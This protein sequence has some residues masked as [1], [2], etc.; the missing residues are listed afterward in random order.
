MPKDE[1]PWQSN[2]FIGS[3]PSHWRT[4]V[5]NYAQVEYHNVYPGIDLI[6][7]G[8][9]GQLEYD[10]VIAPGSDAHS[11]ILNFPDTAT[12]RLDAHGNLQLDSGSEELK[13]HK[14]AAYQVIDGDKRP[15]AAAYSLSGGAVGFAIGDYDRTKPLVIDP[16]LSYSTYLGGSGEDRGQGIAVDASGAVYVVGQSASTDFA[17]QNPFQS[18]SNGG[19]DVFVAK[20]NASGTGLVYSTFL[21][22]TNDD[23]G[24]GIAVDGAGNAYIT[25]QTDSPD[26]PLSNALQGAN[27]G[28]EDAFVSKLSPTGSALLYSTYLGGNGSDFASSIAIDSS[29][30]AY[31][32]GTT[33]SPDFPVMNPIQASDAGGSDAF[34]TKLNPAGSALVYSTYLGGA[35]I[36]SATAIAVDAV[37][38]AYITGNTDS[39]TFPTTPGAFDTSCGCSTDRFYYYIFRDAWLAK[40]D[41]TGS[42]LD[43]S[44][45]LGGAGDDLATG[46]AVDASGQA[47]VTGRTDSDD[48]PLQNPVQGLLGGSGDSFVTALNATGSALVFSTYLGG[49]SFDEGAGIALDNSG[50][51]Y[52]SGR[53]LSNDFPTKSTFQAT[54]G[55]ASDAY[56]AKLSSSGSLTYSS[57]L[58][59][60]VDED[61]TSGGVA[62]DGSGNVY[63]T[64]DTSSSNYPTRSPLQANLRG[65][66]DAFVTKISAAAATGAD[67]SLSTSVTPSAGALGGNLTYTLTV[68][69]H[70]PD[71]ATGVTLTDALG[72]DV[73]FTSAVASQGSCS[74]TGPV[75]CALGSLANGKGANVSLIVST[76]KGAIVNNVASVTA[77]ESD[78]SSGNNMATLQTVVNA[79]FTVAVAPATATVKAGSSA[80]FTLTIAAGGGPFS[81]DISLACSGLPQLSQCN[82][83][84]SVVNLGT[85]ASASTNATVSVMTTASIGTLKPLHEIHSLYALWFSIFSLVLIWTSAGRKKKRVSLIWLAG[86]FLLPLLALQVAC[87]GGGQ[88]QITRPG[89]PTGSFTITITASSAG[90]AHSV[91]ANL[92]VQ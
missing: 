84:P 19:F 41:A 42:A 57:Y 34:V 64:G 20:L 82:F 53:T 23:F 22:G 81:N 59:G 31:V 5:S 43:Y 83:S 80:V 75:T 90:T 14:P 71:N 11:I 79:D 24:A 88:N 49:S 68:S 63:V 91:T 85:D 89:T 69:N 38:S 9:Q 15:V 77:N 8:D 73:T 25:G 3:N 60:V 37:G 70:G 18:T 33:G 35:D 66:F 13:L 45:F 72:P 76:P 4:A 40:I 32:A 87:G 17:T 36:D 78:S 74:G 21:G 51:A 12:L 54:L 92:T 67:L 44:T 6:Y 28:G 50:N 46:I 10:F 61:A 48:F 29:G 26:F 52:V 30:N 62:V 65:G 27:H 47:Y 86:T 7:H 39:K 1:L 55:G 16:T 58:G 2:Y 56:L